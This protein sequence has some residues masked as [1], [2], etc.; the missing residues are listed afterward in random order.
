MVE[1]KEE[2]WNYYKAI[3]GGKAK[4]ENIETLC[5]PTNN[6][7]N[8]KLSRI[9]SAF[10][11][12]MKDKYAADLQDFVPSGKRGEALSISVDRNRVKLP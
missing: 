12:A 5:D 8:E 7:I 2:L 1:Y 10:T 11:S 9:R 4:L 3:A 6:S